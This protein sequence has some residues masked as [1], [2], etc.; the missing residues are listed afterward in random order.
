MS[1]QNST[2][3]QDVI[4]GMVEEM[5]IDLFEYRG[6]GWTFQGETYELITSGPPNYSVEIPIPIKRKSDGKI[7]LIDPYVG[8]QAQYVSMISAQDKGSCDV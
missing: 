2:I 3:L 5:V 7:F 8:V 4:Q 6:E 1:E